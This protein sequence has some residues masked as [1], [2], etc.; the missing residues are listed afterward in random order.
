MCN[1]TLKCVHETTVAMEGNKYYIIQVGNLSYPACNTHQLYCIVIC[2]L[3]GST[4]F[5]NI[6][7]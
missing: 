6:I 1:V 5:V 2:G 3:S 4:M 7:S